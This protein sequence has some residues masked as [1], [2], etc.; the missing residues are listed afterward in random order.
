M[1][2]LIERQIESH[3]LVIKVLNNLLIDEDLRNFVPK[4]EKKNFN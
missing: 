1:K 3:H 2:D 4:P